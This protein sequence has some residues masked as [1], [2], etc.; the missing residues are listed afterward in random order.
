[1]AVSRCRTSKYRNNTI[2]SPSHT[3]GH[4][5]TIDGTYFVWFEYCSV[6]ICAVFL[7]E[8]AVPWSGSLVLIGIAS[9][10][11]KAPLREEGS[12]G[13]YFDKSTE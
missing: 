5:I 8:D 7:D 10:I 9:V 1:M 6:R 4:T 13:K 3:E 12:S 11:T 2:V